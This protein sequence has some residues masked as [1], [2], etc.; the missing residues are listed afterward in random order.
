M[1]STLIVLTAAQ[2]KALKLMDKLDDRNKIAQGAIDARI[3]GAFKAY[4][5]KAEASLA[6][7]YDDASRRGFKIDKAKDVFIA[8][9]MRE[10]KAV[11]VE[12]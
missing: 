8:E 10:V 12:L 4:A 9:Y 3:K 6:K 7:V 2:Q 5:D 1:D 11:S